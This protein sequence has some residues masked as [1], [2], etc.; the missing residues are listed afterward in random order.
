MFIARLTVNGL[1]YNISF[2]FDLMLKVYDGQHQIKLYI[3]SSCR[4]I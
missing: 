2:E 1:H 4:A 3:F